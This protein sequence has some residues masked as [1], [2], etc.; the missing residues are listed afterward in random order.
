MRP[1]TS[2]NNSHY[3]TEHRNYLSIYAK[4]RAH[5]QKYRWLLL[6]Q[7]AKLHSTV[8]LQTS[9]LSCLHIPFST[10]QQNIGTCKR[11]HAHKLNFSYD[12]TLVVKRSHVWLLW[13]SCLH[14]VFCI[15]MCFYTSQWVVMLCSM[16]RASHW[17]S[18][19]RV[20]DQ[21]KTLGKTMKLL[22]YMFYYH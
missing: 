5:I 21:Q 9:S 12:F 2:F 14:T 10:H 18:S 20:N 11:T 22:S 4:H 7:P 17:S 8:S 6:R 15:I 19:T 1:I 13:S 3:R 16:C